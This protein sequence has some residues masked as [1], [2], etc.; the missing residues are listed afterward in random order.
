MNTPFA[1]SNDYIREHGRL[2]RLLNDSSA[3]L[4]EAQRIQEKAT[5]DLEQ[6]VYRFNYIVTQTG[7]LTR[8]LARHFE[9]LDFVPPSEIE[10]EAGSIAPE[11]I[12]ASEQV[13][14]FAHLQAAILDAHMLAGE[15][16]AEWR[17]I[18]SLRGML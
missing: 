17:H 9:F 5:L 3:A 12:L 2:V 18:D 16:T 15:Q 7:P 13:N 8:Y 6:Q 14:D 11:V 10:F 1:I 4:L